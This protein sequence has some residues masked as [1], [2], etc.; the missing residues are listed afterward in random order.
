MGLRGEEFLPGR[1]PIWPMPGKPRLT[2]CP[3]SRMFLLYAGDS[4]APIHDDGLQRTT[5]EPARGPRAPA[6]AASGSVLPSPR[7]THGRGL[8]GVVMA[9]RDGDAARTGRRTG[10]RAGLAG[11]RARPDATPTELA[12]DLTQIVGANLRRARVG[13]GLSLERLA[14]QSGVSRAMLSQ[15]EL[16]HSAPTINLL[17]KIAVALDLPFSA[18]VTSKE[19]TGLAVLRAAEAKVLTSHDGTFTSRAL[20]PFDGPRRVEMYELRLAPHATERADA[21]A[22]G[23]IENLVVH[24][25]QLVLEVEEERAALAAGDAIQFRADVPHAYVNP[26]DTEAVMVLVMSYSETVG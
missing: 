18:L 14:R 7:P 6:G 4:H 24:Q 22:P 13:R 20:F 15:I 21:H 10:P 2:D 11:G 26:A 25:G 19:R 5:A 12:A 1:H 3:L 16:G 9:A 8:A 17:W 23:T